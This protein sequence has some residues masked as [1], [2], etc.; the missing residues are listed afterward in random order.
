VRDATLHRLLSAHVEEAGALLAAD[1]AGGAEVPF[2]LANGGAGSRRTPLYCYRPLT[3]RFISEREHRLAGLATTAPALRALERL[4]G[5][6]AYLRRR[7]EDAGSN[8]ARAA[9]RALLAAAFA[10]SE[11]FSLSRE[12]FARAY[13]ELEE[14][15]YAETVLVNVAAPLLGLELESPEVPIT[16][17]ARLVA[18][19]VLP[20]APA[21]GRERLLA[22]VT[23]EGRDALAIA[24]EELAALARS[25]RL[26]DAGA[27]ALAPVGWIRDDDGPWRLAATGGGGRPRMRAVL[28]ARHEDELRAFCA[29]VARR[30]PRGGEL[31]WA[32]GRFE[33]GLERAAPLEA[34][35]DHLLA[36]R[37]LL[38]PEGPG[39]G[40]MPERLG[41][42]CATPPDRPA[43]VERTQRALALEHAV[44]RGV[45]SAEPDADALSAELESHLRSLLRDTL[46]GHLE[47]DLR[48][49]ADLER[50]ESAPD[51]PTLG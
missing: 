34:L 3:G 6:A 17:R 26:W 37:A 49:L 1:A 39:S 7:G 36:L 25:L 40:L 9:L 2:E 31:A 18:P 13:A 27:P 12:R 45:S 16:A 44:V 11:D 42:L 22:V 35:T 15:V 41:A 30:T 24:R 47:P 43:L 20:D 14:A 4:T 48:V 23:V 8:P 32:L 50:T 5:L 19:G 29:L 38:E 51:A 21:E 46:C 33:M 10:G 28:P